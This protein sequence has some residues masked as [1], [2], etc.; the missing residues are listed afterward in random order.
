[1]TGSPSRLSSSTKKSDQIEVV[2]RG[3]MAT[4]RDENLPPPLPNPIGPL[5]IEQRRNIALRPDTVENLVNPR[6]RG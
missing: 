1:M 5:G 3:F 6:W 4:K 2:A